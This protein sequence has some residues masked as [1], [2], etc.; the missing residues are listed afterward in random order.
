M[1][2]QAG[3]LLA[4]VGLQLDASV[5]AS[6]RTALTDRVEGLKPMAAGRALAEALAPSGVGPDAVK[7]CPLV[8][9]LI[10]QSGEA[11]L[12]PPDAVPLHPLLAPWVGADLGEMV[13]HMLLSGVLWTGL[14]PGAADF[15]ALELLQSADAFWADVRLQFNVNGATVVVLA[16]YGPRPGDAPMTRVVRVSGQVLHRIGAS[17]RPNVPGI[18]DTFVAA[19]PVPAEAAAT[20]H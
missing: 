17:I 19:P 18:S 5:A 1:D 15:L 9:V 16:L 10:E 14:S 4:A 2:I 13:A 3:R 6:L 7:S 8:G 11:L 12:I 20:I